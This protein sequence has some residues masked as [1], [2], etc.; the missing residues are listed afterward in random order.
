MFEDANV[1]IFKTLFDAERY[2]EPIDAKFGDHLILDSEGMVLISNA[3]KNSKGFEVTSISESMPLRFD[4]P[5][6][7]QVLRM[8]L[9]QLKY[10]EQHIAEL[11]LPALV[12]VAIKHNTR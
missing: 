9:K 11:D 8:F 5:K 7:K 6:L 2:L 1:D 10:S 4:K 12:K 3:V